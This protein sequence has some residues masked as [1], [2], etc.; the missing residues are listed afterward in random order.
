[1][2]ANDSNNLDT[3]CKQF[4]RL[5]N[6]NDPLMESTTLEEVM[7]TPAHKFMDAPEF[8]QRYIHPNRNSMPN[9]DALAAIELI[10]PET[11]VDC[12]KKKNVD[13]PSFKTITYGKKSFKYRGSV[14]WNDL[15]N[16]IQTSENYNLF[17][18]LVSNWDGKKC[19]CSMCRCAN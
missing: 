18:K 10:V 7:Q 1:M 11:Y 8:Y 15:P 16:C 19:R 14:L 12:E 9:Q 13:A 4:C 2:P 17:K 3:L 6:S 5:I